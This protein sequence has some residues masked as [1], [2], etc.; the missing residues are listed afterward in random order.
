MMRRRVFIVAASGLVS[1][2][3]LPAGSQTAGRVYR[4]GFLQQAA[5]DPESG[6]ESMTLILARLHKLGYV[7]GRKLLIET[8]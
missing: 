3:P 4:L 5:P 1:V 8:R 2:I 7:A 6:K